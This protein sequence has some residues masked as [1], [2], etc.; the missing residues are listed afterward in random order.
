MSDKHGKYLDEYSE[1]SKNRKTVFLWDQVQKFLEGTIANY[2]EA[3]KALEKS[4]RRM[5]QNPRSKSK[6]PFDE[7]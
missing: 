5:Q 2:S 3:A 7:E 1:I 4:R 6:S